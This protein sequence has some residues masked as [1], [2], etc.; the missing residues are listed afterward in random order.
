LNFVAALNMSSGT[1]VTVAVVDTGVDYNVLPNVLQG[2]RLVPPESQDPMDDN[3]HGTAVAGIIG[4]T[5]PLSQIYAVK[6][7][8]SNQHGTVGSVRY[9]IHYAARHLGV[10]VI[11]LSLGSANQDNGVPVYSKNIAN[12]IAVAVSYLDCAVIMAAG[13]DDNAATPQFPAD[14]LSFLPGNTAA[15]TGIISV[16]GVIDAGTGPLF[17]T[18]DFS[19][20]GAD[21][22]APGINITTTAATVIGGGSTTL[23]GTSA[24]APFVSGTAA[25]VKSINPAWTPSQIATQLLNSVQPVYLLN[26]NEVV[27]LMDQEI[28]AGRLDPVAALGAIRFTYTGHNQTV[29]LTTSLSTG[30]QIV[31]GGSNQYTLGS[32]YAVSGDTTPCEAR[33]SNPCTADEP[34]VG[35]GAGQ[36]ILELVEA[37]DPAEDA[38]GTITLTIPGLTFASVQNSATGTILNPTS[39]SF[40][41]IGGSGTLNHVYFTLVQAAQ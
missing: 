11:N 26:N 3:G 38:S 4:G 12:E 31:S 32:F 15:G 33:N 24:A 14:L 39:A 5:A 41:L 29:S 10:K 20:P 9:G 7:L 19:N 34:L 2:P 30:I 18:I 22:A 6:S 27:S 25:L 13:D 37:D 40:S 17:D 28:G 35:L 23:S 21:L 1:G 36:Y 8:D 16:G